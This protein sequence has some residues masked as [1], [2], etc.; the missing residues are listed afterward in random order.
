M[1][2]KMQQVM[3]EGHAEVAVEGAPAARTRIFRL[4]FTPGCNLYRTYIVLLLAMGITGFWY[5]FIGHVFLPLAV[6]FLT[7]CVYYAGKEFRPVFWS[8]AEVQWKEKQDQNLFGTTNTK[9]HM[10]LISHYKEE[11]EILYRTLKA[12]ITAAQNTRW[13]VHIIVACE[14]ASTCMKESWTL[15]EDLRAISSEGERETSGDRSENSNIINFDEWDLSTHTSSRDP[16]N[17]ETIPPCDDIVTRYENKAVV[18]IQTTCHPHGLAGER[19]GLGSNLRWAIHEFVARMEKKGSSDK[20]GLAVDAKNMKLVEELTRGTMVTKLDCNA[21]PLDPVGYFLEL[22]RVWA[23]PG[24][25]DKVAFSTCVCFQPLIPQFSDQCEEWVTDLN[26]AGVRMCNILEILRRHLLRYFAFFGSIAPVAFTKV[27]RNQGLFSSFCIPLE[28]LCRSGNW[29]PWLVQEDLLMGARMYFATG[30]KTEFRWLRSPIFQAPVL[31]FANWFK[32]MERT[33]IHGWVLFGWNFL[34]A[35]GLNV[36]AVGGDEHHGVSSLEEGRNKQQCTL[37]LKLRNTGIERLP[38]TKAV[39]FVWSMTVLFFMYKGFTNS[40]VMTLYTVA[41]SLGKKPGDAARPL[42]FND[43]VWVDE[44]FPGIGLFTMFLLL[45]TIVSFAIVACCAVR[46][47]DKRTPLYS[48]VF[49]LF[50]GLVLTF[51]FV[52]LF[53]LCVVLKALIMVEKRQT[54]KTTDTKKKFETNLNITTCVSV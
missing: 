38:V 14:E 3:G 46:S 27:F 30:G 26:P 10:V 25:F 44:I 29:D 9:Q 15:L 31:D 53:Q 49:T 51:S 12:V 21:F 42:L 24:R 41:T 37:F 50:L 28:L 36:V 1:V 19:P 16:T 33:T 11:K 2:A 43:D 7:C 22:E 39:W 6:G 40:C 4:G 13:P 54:Y 32:Q 8:A 48:F 23:E 5:P 18:T 35:F 47:L 34:A 52:G 45:T 17:F 20:H